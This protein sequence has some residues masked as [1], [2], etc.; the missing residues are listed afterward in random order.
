MGAVGQ[1]VIPQFVGSGQWNSVAERLR[2][3]RI[4]RLQ[5]SAQLPG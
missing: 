2:S 3:S 4:R 5:R 1:G